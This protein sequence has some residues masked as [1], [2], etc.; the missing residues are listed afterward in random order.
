MTKKKFQN[1]ETMNDFLF[2]A[3]QHIARMAPYWV[4][5]AKQS[6]KTNLKSYYILQQ[7]S[8]V[9]NGVNQNS[10]MIREM[11]RILRD[12][13]EAGPSNPGGTAPMSQ[14]QTQ[15]TQDITEADIE[16]AEDLIASL[17]SIK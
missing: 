12:F 17:V 1:Q 10:R 4:V 5:G 13:V 14:Q 7:I 11:R 16:E 8:A 9:A 3:I 2:N 15:Q 6:S